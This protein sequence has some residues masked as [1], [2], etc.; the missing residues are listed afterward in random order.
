MKVIIYSADFSSE[1]TLPYA[2]E[3]VR[4]GFPSPAQDYL[5]ETI[6]LNKEI[7][8]HQATTFFARCV[9]ESM[10]NADIH[11]G[12]LLVIDK[13]IEAKDGDIIVAYIDGEF[14]VKRIKINTTDNS[15]MLMPE[16]EEYEPIRITESQHF[17][18]WGVVTYTIKKMH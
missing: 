3:G 15:L 16:N 11:D 1:L 10:K 18:V 8:R 17:E 6:D 7:I 9:G 5:S 4:A 12:D 13:S 14:T 2:S